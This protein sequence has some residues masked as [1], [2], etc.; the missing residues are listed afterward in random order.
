MQTWR[1]GKILQDSCFPMNIAKFLRIPFLQSTFIGCFCKMIKF[2]KD[3][4]SLFFL[5]DW[6]HMHCENII[7][8]S[9][10]IEMCFYG[11]FLINCFIPVRWAKAITWENF[12]LSK[13]QYTRGNPISTKEGSRLLPGWNFLHVIAE[14]NLWRVYNTGQILA[15]QDRI[16]SRPTRIM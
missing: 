1:P 12:A 13:Q 10:S 3:I 15:K 11:Y 4:F 6:L 9:W 7:E 5:T 8:I 14:C 2:Y 16:S